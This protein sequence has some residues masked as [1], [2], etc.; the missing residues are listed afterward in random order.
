VV[1]GFII[2]A[3]N[4]FGM[5][6]T[7]I[8]S[9]TT[10]TIIESLRTLC[11]WIVQLILHYALAESEYGK[12]HPDIGEEWSIWSWM[13]L[14][15]FVLLI[16]GLFIYNHVVQLPWLDSGGEQKEEEIVTIQDG[17]LTAAFLPNGT[18]IARIDL[19]TRR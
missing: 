4:I 16:T 17:T 15:G 13:E 9:A 12:R 19:A 10:R 7:E 11:I 18:A 14:S 2:C 3:P 1:D 8:T 6:V 5:M